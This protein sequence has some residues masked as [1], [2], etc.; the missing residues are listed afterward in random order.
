MDPSEVYTVIIKKLG[1]EW[2]NTQENENLNLLL[3]KREGGVKLKEKEFENIIT[4]IEHCKDNLIIED[5]AFG[6]LSQAFEST[7]SD[8]KNL[9]SVKK[10]K[11]KI[12]TQHTEKVFQ[13]ANSNIF[14]KTQTRSS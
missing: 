7:I 6:E 9:K 4:F 3:K 14:Q 10:N 8:I 5:E 12:E 11:E 13:V 2:F 1:K